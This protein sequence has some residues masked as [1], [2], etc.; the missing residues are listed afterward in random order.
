MPMSRNYTVKWTATAEHDL[1]SIIGFIAEDSLEDA[2]RILEKIRKK[3]VGLNTLPERGRVVPELKEQGIV[4]YREAVFAPWRIIYRIS[5]Q[6]V[7]V[8]AVLD[9]RRNL[10]DILLDRFVG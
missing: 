8:L 2:V 10:E 6:N 9:A 4:I 5:D 3:A 1:E 7:F